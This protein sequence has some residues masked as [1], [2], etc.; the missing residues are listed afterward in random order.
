MTTEAIIFS[1]F[2]LSSFV[3]GAIAARSIK[4]LSD[5]FVAGASMRWYFLTGTFVASNVSAGLF[6]G[7]TNMAADHGY[8]VYS[9]FFTTAVGYLISISVV[10]VLV[11]RLAQHYEIYDFADILTVR[12]SSNAKI[13]RGLTTFILPIVYVPLLAAQFIALASISANIFDIPYSTALIFI[14]LLIVAYTVLGGMLGV[15]WTDGFQFLVL[16]FGLI[17]AV[18]LVMTHSGHGSAELG[19]QRVISMPSDIFNWTN[20]GWPWQVALGQLAWVFA[21]PVMPHLITRFLTAKNEREILIALPVSLTLGLMIFASI[22]PLGLLGRIANPD[23]AEGGYY[24]LELAS[25]HMGPFFGGFALA[26]IAAAALSTSSTCLIVTGQSISR[27]LYQKWLSPDATDRQVLLVTRFTIIAIGTITFV[28]AYMKL[29]SIFWLV[30]LSASLLA[31]IFF[32][33]IMAGFFFPG[34]S[35]KAAIASIVF[36]GLSSLSVFITNTMLGAHYFISELFA[37][38]IVSGFCMIVFSLRYPATREERKV[39]YK[40]RS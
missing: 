21:I 25:T 31:S 23:L 2:F 29:L 7:A 1:V 33:P 12:Y 4:G 39:F 24:Y 37:G 28:I 40:V 6:L 26:G 14:S 22:V 35:A 10:G 5:Y 27:D 15:V 9:A 17:I 18:P 38:L 8:A 3:I 30:V 34:V 20:E 32:V 16:F 36:G 19:W 13:I 11:N